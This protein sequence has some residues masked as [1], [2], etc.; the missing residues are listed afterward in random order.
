MAYKRNISSTE[1]VGK[2]I[3]T[4]KGSNPMSKLKLFSL[5]ARKRKESID[6]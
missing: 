2:G 4:E 5:I 6:E 1:Q 3:G